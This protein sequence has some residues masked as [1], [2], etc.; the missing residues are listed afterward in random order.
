VVLKARESL[1][2]MS[3]VVAPRSFMILEMVFRET[4]RILGSSVREMDRESK[5]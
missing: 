3:G 1:K 5:W 4:P 2:A